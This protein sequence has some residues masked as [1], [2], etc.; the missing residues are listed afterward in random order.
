MKVLYSEGQSFH[1]WNEKPDR[2]SCKEKTD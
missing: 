2:R 1:E